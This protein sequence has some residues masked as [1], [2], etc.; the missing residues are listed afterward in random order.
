MTLMLSDNEVISLVDLK[1]FHWLLPMVTSWLRSSVL[2][3]VY[4]LVISVLLSPWIQVQAGMN[5][6]V[7]G[8]NGCGKSSL[9]RILGEVFISMVYH[10]KNHF[11]VALAHVWWEADKTTQEQIVLCSAGLSPHSYC[12]AAVCKLILLHS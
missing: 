7:C 2:R 5:V 6:L 9:F 3:Y 11:H 1:K 4:M 8:P 12:A 10:N